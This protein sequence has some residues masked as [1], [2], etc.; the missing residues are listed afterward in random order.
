ME[1]SSNTLKI[2]A[3]A[4]APAPLAAELRAQPGPAQRGDQAGRGG[5]RQP[6][7][8]HTAHG[9]QAARHG[10]GGIQCRAKNICT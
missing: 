8:R 7:G 3:A 6:R 10:R 5:A 4:P 9:R 1:N 2:F